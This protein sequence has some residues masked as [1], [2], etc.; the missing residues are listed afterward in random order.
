MG[1]KKKNDIINGGPIDL[2]KRKEETKRKAEVC[3]KM[4]AEKAK[5]TV[6]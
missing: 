3:Q 5:K 1:W 6:G 4:V 2:I